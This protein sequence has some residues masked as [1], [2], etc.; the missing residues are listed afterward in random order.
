ML[1][2]KRLK[3]RMDDLGACAALL[4]KLLVTLARVR[5]TVGTAE[6]MLQ[7]PFKLCDRLLRRKHDPDRPRRLDSKGP[8]GAGAPRRRRALDRRAEKAL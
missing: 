8:G 3:D 1:H 7:H 5:E 2:A 6:A 4:G